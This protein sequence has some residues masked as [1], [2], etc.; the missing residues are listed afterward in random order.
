MPKK[1]ES[2]QRLVQL[3]EQST[4]HDDGVIVESPKFFPDKVTGQP[5]EHDVVV[6]VDRGHHTLQIALECRDRSRKVDAPQVEGF[7]LKCL[8]TGIDRG[9]IVSSKGFYKPAVAKAEQYGIGCL[10]LE[11]AAGFDWCL[12]QGMH[13]YERR[14]IGIKIGVDPEQDQDV[15]EGFKLVGPD[16]VIYNDENIRNIGVQCIS[17]LNP[18]MAPSDGPK[19]C[20]CVD[21]H[22]RIGLLT[23]SG[24]RV[25][26]AR[27]TI[28]VTYEVVE[29]FAPFKFHQY[30]DQSKE[31]GLYDMVVASVDIESF[32]GDFVMVN[33][34]KKGMSIMFAPHKKA[35]ELN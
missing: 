15:D 10:T 5:R 23:D 13:M 24:V 16:G 29:T 14:I 31:K 2:L 28:Q 21:S 19:I 1:G 35:P 22:P 6:T 20:N 34:G 4:G 17:S 30:T 25:G 32:G 3:I 18:P 9:V 11:Q 33:Q 8:D 12:A 27:L 7:Y 26:I